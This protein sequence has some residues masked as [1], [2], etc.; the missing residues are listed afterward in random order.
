MPTLT[1]Y[2]NEKMATNKAPSTFIIEPAFH[3]SYCD[4]DKKEARTTFKRNFS[5]AL[6]SNQSIDNLTLVNPTAEI[7][8]MVMD[9]FNDKPNRPHLTI[10]ENLSAEAVGMMIQ[11][12]PDLGVESTLHLRLCCQ[13]TDQTAQALTAGIE[14]E[15][16]SPT[17]SLIFGAG[18]S[19]SNIKILLTAEGINYQSLGIA[20]GLDERILANKDIQA[21]LKEKSEAIKSCVMIGDFS[22][23]ATRHFFNAMPSYITLYISG[24]ACKKETKR[25]IRDKKPTQLLFFGENEPEVC[26]QLTK[27]FTDNAKN[28]NSLLV[29]FRYVH[30]PINIILATFKGLFQSWHWKKIKH[31]T[32]LDRSNNDATLQVFFAQLAKHKHT[33]TL[34]LG[35]ISSWEKRQLIVRA[36]NHYN[37]S[38]IEQLLL[39][40]GLSPQAK[41]EIDHAFEGIGFELNAELCY[42]LESES[43][44]F[45]AHAPADDVPEKPIGIIAE[46]FAGV[47]YP[48]NDEKFT[49]IDSTPDG[50]CGYHS[51]AIKLGLLIK[52]DYMDEFK[53]TPAMQTLLQRFADFHPHFKP[54]TWDNLKEWIT[55]YSRTDDYWKGTHTELEYLL[56]PVLRYWIIL[57]QKE[58]QGEDD[59]TNK[60]K[61]TAKRKLAQSYYQQATDQ[62]LEWIA[63]ELGLGLYM[64][65]KDR[66]KAFSS[67]KVEPINANPHYV[68]HLLHDAAEDDHL[69][70]STLGGHYLVKIEHSLMQEEPRSFKADRLKRE[71]HSM[72][73]CHFIRNSSEVFRGKFV[74][75]APNELLEKFHVSGGNDIITKP[76]NKLKHKRHGIDFRDFLED[77]NLADEIPC[78]AFA[79]AEQRRELVDIYDA[80][81]VFCYGSD[82]T[83]PYGDFLNLCMKHQAIIET[84]W[85]ASQLWY[86]LFDGEVDDRELKQLRENILQDITSWQHNIYGIEPKGFEPWFCENYSQGVTPI[87]QWSTYSNL[88]QEQII[89]EFSK[90]MKI[91]RDVR[92]VIEL[93]IEPPPEEMTLSFYFLNQCDEER[94]ALIRLVATEI[95]QVDRN[96]ALWIKNHIALPE[97][98]DDIFTYWDANRETKQ[99][100]QLIAQFKAGP[101]EPVTPSIARPPAAKRAIKIARHNIVTLTPSDLKNPPNLDDKPTFTPFLSDFKTTEAILPMLLFCKNHNMDNKLIIGAGWT[102]DAAFG[103]VTFLGRHYPK[104]FFIH[105]D[106]DLEQELSQSL[107]R[108]LASNPALQISHGIVNVI[109][110][111]P[112]A[113][114]HRP[115]RR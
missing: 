114:Q 38:T 76:W 9:G 25:F 69:R 80:F 84:D 74:F 109:D 48:P 5:D 61:K 2:T 29:G 72:L 104:E 86:T 110:Q 55:I 7:I 90:W 39:Q 35:P 50:S 51:I 93:L 16:N 28:M 96:F 21:L 75:P 65:L 71:T 67:M 15:E 3:A 11:K 81:I 70:E 52:H 103:L 79:N 41:Q 100:Q 42:D 108:A 99:L 34:Y 19:I 18:L 14:A 101:S 6:R 49:T 43:A 62:E 22:R 87:T 102:E 105:I 89:D 27:E 112:S 98:H 8:E 53:D 88:E 12:L 68:A 1:R 95:A 113:S 78:W 40:G 26:R 64:E 58:A 37:L 92:E 107:I 31:F 94:Q 91:E 57:H 73:V 97:D 33:E 56:A 54:T 46:A 85:N 30:D 20:K 83:E 59:Y 111:A 13:M 77:L 32:L 17:C 47:A 45:D 36:L 66:P 115:S 63:K 44:F 24:D 106:A 23:P 10:E 60:Q 82:D 4:P